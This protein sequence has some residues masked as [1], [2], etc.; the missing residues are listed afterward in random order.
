[1]FRVKV[2]I[3]SID[4]VKME[5]NSRRR[6]GI[7]DKRLRILITIRGRFST[8]IEFE[9]GVNNRLPCIALQWHLFLIPGLLVLLIAPTVIITKSM[10]AA[11]A[12]PVDKLKYE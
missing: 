2:I 3:L 9:V 1:M 5:I 11:V 7:V 10:R 12:N 4:N 8:K 6:K